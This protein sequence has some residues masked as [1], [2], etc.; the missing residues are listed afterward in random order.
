M[1]TSPKINILLSTY[2]G[3]P[4]LTE[5]LDSLFQQT[6]QNFTLY[7][8]DDASKDQTVPLLH[9]YRE[10]HPEIADRIV[11]LPNPEHRNL[12][13]MESFWTLLRE[14]S[15]AD[16]YAFCDQ[17]DVWLPDKLKAGIRFL[18]KE[19]ARLPLLYFS[20]YHY[21]DQDLHILH[22]APPVSLPITFK[23]VL[24]Y[25]PAF[26]FS[27]MINN[28]LRDMALQ[29]ADH[30]GLPHDG[31]V[32]KIAAAFGKIVYN[33]DCTALYRRHETAVTSGNARL[34][35]AIRYWVKSDL[36]GKAMQDT[37]FVLDRFLQEYGNK[38]SVPDRELLSLYTGNK[39]SVIKWLKRFTYSQRLRPSAGGDLALRICLFWGRY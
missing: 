1:N 12:G 3:T 31:W 17:D 14:C 4:Y 8:R 21:C 30:S 22:D 29:P 38:L 16:Y 26:G 36:L 5:Q 2:N 32:Q 6:F 27:I 11:I 28:T 10:N 18:E 35:S 39:P 37:H 25:T 20:N 33:P 9:S 15:R 23:D 34:Q 13:Y 7:V 19:D 24:F